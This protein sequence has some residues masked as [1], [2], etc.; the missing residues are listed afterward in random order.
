M[1]DSTINL[2]PGFFL[3]IRKGLNNLNVNLKV[4]EILD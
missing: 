1:K 4:L 2:S 3:I